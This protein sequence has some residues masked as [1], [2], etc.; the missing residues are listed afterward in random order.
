MLSPEM[1][2]LLGSVMVVLSLAGLGA[3]YHARQWFFTRDL[4]TQ[5]QLADARS[6]QEHQPLQDV[7]RQ[8]G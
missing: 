3:A 7:V 1:Y 8:R 4:R 5:W 2:V 6:R